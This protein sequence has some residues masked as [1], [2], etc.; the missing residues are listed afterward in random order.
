MN[1]KLGN[2]PFIHILALVDTKVNTQYSVWLSVHIIHIVYV[3]YC[4]D[5]ENPPVSY[6]KFSPNGKYILAGTL[7]K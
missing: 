6:V 3:L 4:T 5:D 1:G 7:D 2:F